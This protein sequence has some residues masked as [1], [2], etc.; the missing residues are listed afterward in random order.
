MIA[1]AAF[2]AGLTTFVLA[3]LAGRRAELSGAVQGRHLPDLRPA[4][5]GRRP[6]SCSST[7]WARTTS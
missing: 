7:W 6:Y 5:R 4:Y 3:G 2:L 1:N